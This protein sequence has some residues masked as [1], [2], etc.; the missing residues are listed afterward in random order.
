MTARYRLLPIHTT[1]P[2]QPSVE[3][4]AVE[5]VD[6]LAAMRTQV[7]VLLAALSDATAQEDASAGD[8]L[9]RLHFLFGA[10]EDATSALAR[11]VSI[12]E[13]LVRM[14]QGHMSPATAEELR[15]E[16]WNILEAYI[17][18]RQVLPA[19]DE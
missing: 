9:S 12:Y 8:E 15:E 11:L 5:P 10:K 16:D 6:I 1:S 3:T 7:E 17:Q 2:T 13:K 18:R 14:E 4:A 19:A